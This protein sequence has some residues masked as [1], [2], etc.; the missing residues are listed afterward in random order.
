LGPD[1]PDTATS[2]N[3]LAY[4]YQQQG[5]YSDAEPLLRQALSI[6]EHV[7][8]PEHPDTANSLWWLAVLAT[9]CKRI[10]EAQLLYQ[11]AIS[12]YERTLGGAHPTTQRIQQLYTNLLKSLQQDDETSL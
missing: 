11:R 1:H 9:Q 2:L 3:N 7:F 5:R 10:Q 6:R 4:L 12:I 8:G